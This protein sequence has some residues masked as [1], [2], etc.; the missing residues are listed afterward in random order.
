VNPSSDISVPWGNG[1]IRT[2]RVLSESRHLWRRAQMSRAAPPVIVIA[3]LAVCEAVVVAAA[4]AM[5]GGA[6]I[7]G[8]GVLGP[9]T[10]NQST[11][12]VGISLPA[13]AI[14]LVNWHITSGERAYF[15]VVTSPAIVSL[16]CTNVIPPSNASCP[17]PGCMPPSYGLGLPICVEAG[18]NG[19][20]SFEA[21]VAGYSALLYLPYSQGEVNLIFSVN[22]SPR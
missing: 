14:A 7:A 1:Y 5:G 10:L 21:A 11:E 19:S 2:R 16:N 6:T 20:C 15:A 3:L 9:Y 13:C 22:Y 18:T 17:A 12:S 8:V 4:I